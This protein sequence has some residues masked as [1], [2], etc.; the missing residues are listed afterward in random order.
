MGP[1]AMSPAGGATVAAAL[2]YDFDPGVRRAAAEA[3]AA[4][5]LVPFAGDC[6]RAAINDPDPRVRAA[7]A[8]AHARLFG[9]GKSPRRAA[10][11][12]LLCPG[13]GHFYLGQPR[14]AIG[15]LAGTVALFG[16]GLALVLPSLA[17]PVEGEP[18]F[19]PRFEDARGPIGLQ[20]LLAGQNLWF[21]SVYA[22]Y[23]DAR[24]LRNDEGYRFA[25]TRESLADL[26]V[27]PVR[28]RVLARPWFWAGLPIMFGAALA[29]QSAVD[30]GFGRDAGRW[31][32]EGRDVNF[33]GRR[34]SAGAG[35]ALGEAYYAALFW[36]VGVGEEA[37]FRGVVQPGLSESFGPWG[38]WAAA[39]V[40][41]GA[42]HIGNF[43]GASPEQ[44]RAGLVAVPFI[45]L[46]GS[47]LGLVSLYTGNRLETSV[48]LHFWYD[49]LLG[50]TSFLADP[51]N[52]PFTVRIGFGI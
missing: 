36:P 44:A 48:A 49:F 38:G 31:L 42:A 8:A 50:T 43:V 51:E 15:L 20:L 19:A 11:Y 1:W 30:E 6:E 41:F 14:V 46:V 35:F 29:L 24:A 39:S 34:M 32:F 22:A 33:L 2:A 18:G 5:G 10:A 16:T 21:Y 12:S 25:G 47:Y 17:T 26:A 40:I 23:R 13:C 37:L 4:A 45:T 27:A 52:Q 3:L 28:P 7:A 9:L